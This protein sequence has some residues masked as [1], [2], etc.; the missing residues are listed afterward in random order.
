MG[1]NKMIN[2]YNC[3]FS[4]NNVVPPPFQIY[5]S[6]LDCIDKVI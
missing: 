2:N 1:E 4:E 6:T 3:V 5:R